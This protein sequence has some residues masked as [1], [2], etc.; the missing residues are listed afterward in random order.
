MQ[1]SVILEQIEEKDA[2]LRQ[3]KGQGALDTDTDVQALRADLEK[4]QEDL[5]KI[6]IGNLIIHI[7]D[8][9]KEPGGPIEKDQDLYII[10]HAHRLKIKKIKGK[11]LADAEEQRD[12]SSYHYQKWERKLAE[13]ED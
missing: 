7:K 6:D 2:K 1:K 8:W 4:L 13:Y 10:R 5:E 11:E 12:R 3:K 9:P